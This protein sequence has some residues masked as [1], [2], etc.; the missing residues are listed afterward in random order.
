VDAHL[1]CKP[2]WYGAH[3]GAPSQEALTEASWKWNSGVYPAEESTRVRVKLADNSGERRP[4]EE[5]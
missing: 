4:E 5:K 3:G 1:C 2:A